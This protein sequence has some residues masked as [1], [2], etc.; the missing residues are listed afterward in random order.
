MVFCGE[1]LYSLHEDQD[2]FCRIHQKLSCALTLMNENKN[3]KPHTIL[4]LSLTH[5]DI[6]ECI[7]LQVGKRFII[8]VAYE[9][10]LHECW[11]QN[12]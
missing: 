8:S 4:W 10:A 7:N 9:A 6:Q 2:F 12:K 11:R 1:F 3:I 5:H